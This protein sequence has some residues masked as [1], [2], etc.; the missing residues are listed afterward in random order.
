M[1][2]A[3]LTIGYFPNDASPEYRFTF[4][5]RCRS[6]YRRSRGIAEVLLVHHTDRVF[7]FTANQWRQILRGVG[8]SAVIGAGV[9]V[10]VGRST[11]PAMG[12]LRGAFI[13]AL[14]PMLIVV[15]REW[16]YHSRLARLP[17]A[18]FTVV[19]LACN[20]L[21]IAL[22]VVIASLPFPGLP[23]VVV[24]AFV[25]GSVLSVV[26]TAWYTVDR[27]LGAGVLAGLLTGRYHTPRYEDRVFLFAD[28]AGSTPLAQR[29]GGLRYHNLLN[30]LFEEVGPV[31]DRFGGSVHSY[32]GDEVIVTWPAERGIPNAVCLR[33]ALEMLEVVANEAARFEAEFGAAPRLRIAMHG[34]E[35]VAGEVAGLKRQVVFSGDTI[36][37]VARIEAVAGE[38]DRSLVISRELLARLEMPSNL[39]VEPLGSYQLKGRDAPTELVAIEPAGRIVTAGT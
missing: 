27:L 26:F 16:L 36:N 33:C 18:P 8:V 35:V 38:T 19:N 11:S 30:E 6:P 34:G 2:T 9:G 32:V 3:P 20:A 10:F 4:R 24:P 17:F 22:A 12:A 23:D 29:L 7:R 14:A 37:T 15:A 39:R 28:L 31:V 1:T 13:G 25:A 21:A 5:R